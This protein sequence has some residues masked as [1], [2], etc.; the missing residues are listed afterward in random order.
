MENSIFH[1][2][3]KVVPLPGLLELRVG[4]QV[5]LLDGRQLALDGER[6]LLDLGARHLPLDEAVGQVARLLLQEVHPLTQEAILGPQA[7]KL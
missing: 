7:L 3:L 1:L 2:N 4:V 5:V 6:R